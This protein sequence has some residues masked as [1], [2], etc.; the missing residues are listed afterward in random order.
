VTARAT[1]PTSSN[2]AKKHSDRFYASHDRSAKAIETVESSEEVPYKAPKNLLTTG[3][4]FARA[5]LTMAA[6]AVK[7][8]SGGPA[9]GAGAEGEGVRSRR[10][11]P[12][13]PA[14]AARGIKD[15]RVDSRKNV[16]RAKGKAVAGTGSE[17]GSNNGG[18][19]VAGEA[20]RAKGTRTADGKYTRR[21]RFADK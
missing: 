21:P 12:C 8:R 6:A 4:R 17:P 19:A 9:F 11:P 2:S 7:A 16:L 18:S 10:L 20:A 5:P 13:P 1:T 3:S 15:P 14:A